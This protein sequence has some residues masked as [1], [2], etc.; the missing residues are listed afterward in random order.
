[1]DILKSGAEFFCK[2]LRVPVEMA[3]K[4]ERVRQMVAEVEA[5]LRNETAAQVSARFSEWQTEFPRIFEMLL[6]RDYPRDVLEMMLK[7]LEKMEQGSVSQ[8][9]ASV[10]VGGVLETLLA[11]AVLAGGGLAPARPR[12][13]L[14][15][16]AQCP[17]GTAHAARSGSR[18]VEPASGGGGGGGGEVGA[19]RAGAPDVS[20]RRV[21]TAW[22]WAGAVPAAA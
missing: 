6:T 9:N 20:V 2:E 19:C 8:H 12:D 15:E 7:N 3:S 14:G 18:H 22:D 1:M 5:A 4:S 13:A 11:G 10:A 17:A 21:V 16:W